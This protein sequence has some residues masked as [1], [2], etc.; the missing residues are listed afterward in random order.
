LS[1]PELAYLSE[2]ATHRGVIVFVLGYLNKDRR[3][4]IKLE[5]IRR[6]RPMLI[7]DEALIATALSDTEDRRRAL[8]EIAQGYSVAD[9]YKDYGRSPV[10][11]EMFKGRT[12]E[13]AEITDPFGPY[14]VYGG[15]RLGKTALLRH[16]VSQPVPNAAFA[17]VDLFNLT[18]E[19][20][21]FEKVAKAFN[22]EVVNASTRTVREFAAGIQQWLGLDDR[23]R[24]LLLLDEADTF[25][26]HEAETGFHCISAM[27]QLMAETKNRFKFV[28]AGLH[29]VSR[30]ARAENSPLV[31]I[32]NNPL[33]IGPLIDRDVADAEFLVADRLQRWGTNLS[34]GRTSGAF[35]VLPIITLS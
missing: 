4:Q 30:A 8:I 16:I 17:F 11:P 33:R 23:R 32:S 12:H 1:T 28:L 18:T 7:I 34:D 6:K 24:V 27:L 9:P 3:D 35:S 29:N 31:Q 10:P 21:I 14:V 26:R 15:R 2:G 22:N 5:L 19:A 25:V 20:D 13:R